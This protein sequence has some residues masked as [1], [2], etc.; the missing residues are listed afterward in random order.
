M[1]PDCR[2]LA[3]T[4]FKWNYSVKTSLQVCL[5]TEAIIAAG[6]SWD[7]GQIIS[8]RRQ[9]D[10]TR[11]LHSIFAPTCPVI[12]HTLHD[13]YRPSELTSRHPVTCHICN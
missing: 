12:W 8:R 1:D 11:S 7:D 3:V 4:C 5:K 13:N 10:M 2:Q 9:F 6:K